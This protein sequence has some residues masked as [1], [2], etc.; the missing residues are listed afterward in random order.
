MSQPQVEYI[1]PTKRRSM[2]KQ[3]RTRIF[4]SRNG[5]CCLCGFQIRAHAEDWFIEHPEAINLG[6]SDDDADL[7]PA[8]VRCK[9]AKD[10]AD[11]AL[12]AER[13]SVID[14]HC[15]DAPR[16]SRPMPGSKAS[17]WKK[18]MNG[19]AVRR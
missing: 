1:A 11:A 5:V 17:G 14:K 12:I 4:L 2:S 15:A 9:P 19:P 7:H 10:A 13:N 6:G 8:H 16:K 18:P 3:R